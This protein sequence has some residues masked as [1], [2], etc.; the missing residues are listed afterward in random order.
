MAGALGANRQD[1]IVTLKACP[2]A[3]AVMQ[4]G[5]K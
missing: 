3:D 5:V 2:T 1:R 4:A